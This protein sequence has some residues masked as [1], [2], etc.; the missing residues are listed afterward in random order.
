MLSTVVVSV[1][2]V[3]VMTR[4]AISTAERPEYCQTMLTT[5]ISILGK[6]SVGVLRMDNGP[7]INNKSA[8]TA[9]V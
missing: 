6:M 4:L 7:M 9:K 5:G 8:K 3:M 1:R 2:S